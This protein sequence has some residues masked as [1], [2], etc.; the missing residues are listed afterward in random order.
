MSKEQ[1]L[2]HISS[3]SLWNILPAFSKQIDLALV[4]SKINSQMEPKVGGFFHWIPQLNLE[5]W[6]RYFI[7]LTISEIL[8]V[9]C[10][11]Y[12]RYLCLN[13]MGFF[14]LNSSLYFSHR[15]FL[16]KASLCW[17]AGCIMSYMAY[18]FIYSVK[19]ISFNSKKQFPY[20]YTC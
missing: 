7:A 5:S 11:K 6:N 19:F 15:L 16:V 13:L 4:I 8:G 9:Q 14:A 12:C 2:T 10:P 18:P 3:D 1:K 20:C 17:H